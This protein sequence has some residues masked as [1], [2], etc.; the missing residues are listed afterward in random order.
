MKTRHSKSKRKPLA[1]L[2]LA[3]G[4]GTRMNSARNKMLHTLLGVP[5]VAYV[6]ERA[7]GA[8]AATIVT[9]L[10]HQ[11]NEVVKVIEDRFGPGSITVVE[12]KEQRGT[13]HA[14]RLGLRPLLGF[15]GWVAI[16]Y[17]DVPLLRAETLAALVTAARRTGRL[18]MLTSV[19]RDPTGYGRV[20][21]D[22]RGL[23]CRVVEHKDA[24]HSQHRI[25]EVNAGIY[26]A[27]AAFLRK[28]TAK[29]SAR[30]AQGEYYL[31]DIVA[32]A[33]A[34]IGVVSVQV[35]AEEMTGINDR[36][37]LVMAE[38]LLLGSIVRGHMKVATFRVPKQVY[39]EASV[40]I[41]PDAEIGRN[42]VLRGKTRIGARARIDD[43]CLLNDTV[44][45]PGAHVLPYCVTDGAVIGE[46]AKVG[47]F[48]HLRPG[49]VL[50]PDVHVGNFV[51]TKK[52]QL[53]RGSKAN[54]LTYL[55]DTLVGEKVNVGAG[56]ITCN[57]NGYEKRQ[58]VIEDGAFIGSDTQLVAPV[59]VG[60]RAVVAAGATIV[61][62]VR[63]GVL[64]ISRA[65]CKQI[66]GYADRLA[67]RYRK[68]TSR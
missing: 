51:E 65:P 62:D 41:E 55:G 61:E 23:I 12:Q 27:P 29:L 59:R 67:E 39:V 33:A 7:R 30:N 2:I 43:G 8:G 24:S 49:T 48:A 3:A 28:A 14:V 64:A 38:R 26:V 46:Q 4:K 58:T 53:G 36:E 32:Q 47:P 6:V 54:H 13:G 34:G 52:A 17:G 35:P 42:V 10:G 50:G 63:P 20:V 9:V 15:D 25:A 21:R 66:D 40:G 5:M 56:T 31:T 11:K 37:Q 57:Y 19:V 18:A 45:G 22:D 1:C 16:L 60:K 68:K 44:V